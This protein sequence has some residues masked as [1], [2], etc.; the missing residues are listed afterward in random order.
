M[1]MFVGAKM[2][3]LEFWFILSHQSSSRGNGLWEEQALK[4]P[5]NYILIPA[6]PL[7]WLNEFYKVI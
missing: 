1:D 2:V 4:D 7:Y 6:L 5:K 3:K